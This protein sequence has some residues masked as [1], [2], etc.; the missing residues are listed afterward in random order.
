MVTF[1][2][3]KCCKLHDDS[4]LLYCATGGGGYGKP[5]AHASRNDVRPLTSR[6]NAMP[7]KKTMESL[8]DV[9]R[10]RNCSKVGPHVS[11]SERPTVVY[12]AVDLKVS[13]SFFYYNGVATAEGRQQDLVQE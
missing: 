1:F 11:S 7:S 5:T 4:F 6:S 3:P 12:S 2:T 9:C 8:E 10:C 13:C